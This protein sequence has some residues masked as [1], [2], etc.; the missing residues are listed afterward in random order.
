MAGVAEEE[1]GVPD[2]DGGEVSAGAVEVLQER[3]GRDGEEAG[4][5]RECCGDGYASRAGDDGRRHGAGGGG[6]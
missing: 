3:E 1:D 4:E 6:G 5:D 2:G